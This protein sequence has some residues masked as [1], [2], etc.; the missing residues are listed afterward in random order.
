MTFPLA[1]HGRAYST[2]PRGAELAIEVKQMAGDTSRVE[3]D[4]AGV[5]SVSYSFADEFVGELFEQYDNG[6]LSFTPVLINVPQPLARVITACLE[7]RGV[8]HHCPTPET[9]A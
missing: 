6:H 4:F 9:L 8:S 7:A 3:I 1:A 5:Q 2:R